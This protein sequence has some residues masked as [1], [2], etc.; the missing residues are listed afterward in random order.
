M[1]QMKIQLHS[2]EKLQNEQPEDVVTGTGLNP[3]LELLFCRP[4]V[5]HFFTLQTFLSC[6]HFSKISSLQIDVL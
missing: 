5:V 3:P 6:T 2:A 4:F 1:M